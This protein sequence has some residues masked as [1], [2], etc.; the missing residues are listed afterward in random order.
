MQGWGVSRVSFHREGGAG[1]R[2]RDGHRLLLGRPRSIRSSSQ[3]IT[4]LGDGDTAAK[5]KN[6]CA[7][8]PPSPPPPIFPRAPPSTASST[9]KPDLTCLSL[10]SLIHK[11]TSRDRCQSDT[12]QC[13]L[14]Q[15]QPGAHPIPTVPFFTRRTPILL[16]WL[17]IQ[18]EGSPSRAPSWPRGPRTSVPI[19]ESR[20]KFR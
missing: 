11:M 2:L 16:G 13:A 8:P 1:G 18:M 4:V 15:M 12:E 14:Y 5:P 10:N 20:W 19:R 17:C 6:Q 7:V 3:M 9:G